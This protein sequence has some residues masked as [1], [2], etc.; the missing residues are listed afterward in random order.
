MGTRTESKG[1]A[2]S[3]LE[4]N[5]SDAIAIHQDGGTYIVVATRLNW[6]DALFVTVYLSN[7]VQAGEKSGTTAIHIPRGGVARLRAQLGVSE[8]GEIP[9]FPDGDAATVTLP[10]VVIPRQDIGRRVRWG[11]AHGKHR[12]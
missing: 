2:V 12:R 10:S 6:P 4:L 9:A 1:L 7:Q 5:G 3:R 11:R 8:T